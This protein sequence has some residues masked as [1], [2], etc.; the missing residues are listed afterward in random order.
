MATPASSATHKA[1]PTPAPVAPQA[2]PPPPTHAEPHS[3]RVIAP[4]VDECREND[5]CTAAIAAPGN[6][7][8][9]LKAPVDAKTFR[10]TEAV[11]YNTTRNSIGIADKITLGAT[12]FLS[13]GAY[14]D[15]LSGT[16]GVDEAKSLIRA[17]K[18][19]P[20]EKRRV[21]AATLQAFERTGQV[22]FADIHIAKKNAWNDYLAPFIKD[23]LADKPLSEAEKATAN[24][25]AAV[26]IVRFN[27]CKSNP[28]WKLLTPKQV[29]WL[30]TALQSGS[31][32]AEL[33]V[34]AK[35]MLRKHLRDAGFPKRAHPPK[36][37]TRLKELIAE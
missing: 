5:K 24:L 9:V 10:N 6:P 14:L 31:A 21:L 27:V 16:I 7:A 3:A 1:K 29:D 34:E 33:V 15:R 30:A 17:A 36:H 32:P 23:T 20:I 8:P 13:A 18:R 19:Y 35:A 22:G 2:A 37:V 26:D 4:P 12:V 25:M 28:P 11:L